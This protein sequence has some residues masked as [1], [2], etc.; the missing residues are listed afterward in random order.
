MASNSIEEL[1]RAWDGESVVVR[2]DAP[3]GTWIFI[4]LHSSRLG[5]PTGGCRMKV[6]TEPADGLRDAM[7]LAEGMTCKW[8]ALEMGCGGGKAVLAVPVMLTGE[9]RRG[10]LERFARLLNRL[11]GSFSTGRD[12]GTTDDDMRVMAGISRWVHGIDRQTGAARDPGPYTARGVFAAI[13][14]TGKQLFGTA[15]L[16][17]RSILIQGTGAVGAPLARLLAAQGATLLL[18]DVDTGAVTSLAQELGASLVAPEAV[19]DTVCDIYAPC[20]MGATLDA[21]AIRRLQCRAVTGSA[22]NQLGEPAD[23]DRLHQ[24]GILYAPDYITNGGGAKAFL[25]IQQG[26]KDEDE[27]ALKMDAI[28][29]FLGDIF[30][31]AADKAESPARTA[32]RRVDAVLAAAAER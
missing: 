11:R 16:K 29:D 2:F 6:Y 7:R 24:R 25:S 27:L 18:S 28:G 22:N 30:T 17:G 21:A 13:R 23:A 31:E 26:I 12:L 14:A 1:I 32:R 15:D 3:T 19:I 4:A 5:Q 8:A 10:L 9:A 20:A